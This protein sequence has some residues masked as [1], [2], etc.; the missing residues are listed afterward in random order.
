M[1]V[2]S[3]RRPRNLGATRPI[4]NGWSIPKRWPDGRRE[5]ERVAA[6]PESSKIVSRAYP[7]RGQAMAKSRTSPPDRAQLEPTAEIQNGNASESTKQIVSPARRL[8]ASTP[9]SVPHSHRLCRIGVTIRSDRMDNRSAQPTRPRNIQP[10]STRPSASR[11][12]AA[13]FRNNNSVFNRQKDGYTNM[14]TLQMSRA[15]GFVYLCRW[16]TSKCS[17]STFGD[18]EEKNG[19]SYLE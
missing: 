8:T 7:R 12:Y 16:R 9:M 13:S 4:R 2:P 18:L 6:R 5:V 14:E 11:T 19:G 10:D 1:D 15:Y 3:F 17:N